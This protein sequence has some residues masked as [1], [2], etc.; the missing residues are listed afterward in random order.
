MQTF[1]IYQVLGKLDPA[2]WDNSTLVAQTLAGMDLDY[3]I[4]PTYWGLKFGEGKD[5]NNNLRSDQF[6]VGQWQGG[7][8]KVVGPDQFATGTAKVPW[9]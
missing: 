1:I 4:M 7:E 8:Y 5:A 3:G 2:D 9:Q 6:I